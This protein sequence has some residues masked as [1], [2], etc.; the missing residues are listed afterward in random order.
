MNRDKESRSSSYQILS[1]LNSIALIGCLYFLYV[2]VFILKNIC[3]SCLLIDT[4]VFLNYILLFKYLRATLNTPRMSFSQLF[5]RNLLFYIS[6]LILFFSGIVIYNTYQN[7]INNNNNKLLTEF[8]LLKP[9]KDIKCKN[10]I[11]FGNKSGEIK[12]RIFS[13]ILCSYCKIASEK[14]RQIFSEDSTVY[15]EFVYYPLNYTNANKLES[16]QLNVFLSKVMLAASQDK[17]FWHFHDLILKQSNEIDS[18]KIFELG[19]KTLKDYEGFR[20]DF[21]TKNYDAILKENIA[22]S[23]EYKVSG[24][25]G[26]FINGREFHQWTNINL[27]DMIVSSYTSNKK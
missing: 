8:L 17:E 15:I 5:K 4:I 11:Y 13:D 2:L 16:T 26:V 18:A 6:F 3:V 21:F 22:L 12:I 23:Q 9:K 14:Y 25:P 20:D 10:S 27:L 1:I 19:K 24:T 7:I